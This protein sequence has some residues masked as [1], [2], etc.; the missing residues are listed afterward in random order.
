M[1]PPVSPRQIREALGLSVE[2]VCI[3]TRAAPVTVRRFEAN[4][5][6]VSPET[7]DRLAHWYLAAWRSA[8]RVAAWYVRACSGGPVPNPVPPMD[9]AEV[10]YA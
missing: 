9:H 4:A 6:S 10:G 8:G 2:D 1:K 7:A 5:L 3:D